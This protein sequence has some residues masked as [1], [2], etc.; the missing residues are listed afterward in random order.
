MV[1]T[2][3]GLAGYCK[4]CDVPSGAIKGERHDKATGTDQVWGLG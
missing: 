3:G 4:D 2:V 1:Q